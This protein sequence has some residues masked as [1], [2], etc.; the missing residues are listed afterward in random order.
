MFTYGGMV[1][2]VLTFAAYRRT[3]VVLALSGT[4]TTIETELGADGVMP[5]CAGRWP[6]A[7]SSGPEPVA[8]QPDTR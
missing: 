7:R 5:R 1:A 2:H 3:V 4:A 8:S 6:D